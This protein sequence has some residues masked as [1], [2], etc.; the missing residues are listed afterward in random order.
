MCYNKVGDSMKLFELLKPEELFHPSIFYD[1]EWLLGGEFSVNS[2]EEDF[3]LLNAKK[4]KGENAYQKFLDKN[5]YHP[6]QNLLGSVSL[7][8]TFFPKIALTV[9]SSNEKREVRFDIAVFLYQ[10]LLGLVDSEGACQ[11]FGNFVAEHN[12]KQEWIAYIKDELKK[13]R[14]IYFEIRDKGRKSPYFGDSYQTYLEYIRVSKD[15]M[16]YSEFLEA[17]ISGITKLLVSSRYYLDFFNKEIPVEEL[18][19][20]FDYDTFCLVAAYSVI[21]C[22]RFTES[23][24]NTINNAIIYVRRYLDAVKQIREE[25]PS[26]DCSIMIK[27][28]KRTIRIDDIQKEYESL[29]ARHPEFSVIETTDEEIATLL[30]KDGMK[31]EE[32]QNI[33]I[34]TR[35]NQEVVSA[36]LQKFKED[37]ELAAEWEFIPKGTVVETSPIGTSS[38]NIST[39]IPED[40]QIRRML[41]GRRYLENSKYLFKIYGVN[42]FKGYIGYIYPNETVIF[43]KYYEN[44]NTKKVAH[45]SATYVMNLYNFMEM[46]KL[47]KM[48]IIQMMRNDA[49]IK[50][51]RIYHRKDMDKWKSQIAQAISGDDYNEAVISYIDSLISQD[52]LKKSEVQK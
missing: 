41:I 52:S 23:Q 51:K 22:C 42:K 29:L 15:M 30:R 9:D 46:S 12:N 33:D 24:T 48:E 1:G 35:S 38:S 19:D 47:S 7:S 8:R 13:D 5:Y 44:D 2:G 27:N 10:Q 40:E 4:V 32:I 50:I 34:S 16:S 20:A 36:L 49:G 21:V 18:L 37:K 43:E 11:R 25:M 26:Y 28:S 6:M 3:L 45:S 39:P 14:K 17:K 31:E